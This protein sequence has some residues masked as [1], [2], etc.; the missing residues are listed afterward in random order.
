MILAM[1]RHIDEQPQD[2]LAMIRETLQR[3]DATLAD[4]SRDKVGDDA[5][6]GQVVRFDVPPL[7]GRIEWW[8]RAANEQEERF[9]MERAARLRNVQLARASAAAI[10]EQRIAKIEAQLL[11]VI[12]AMSRVTENVEAELRESRQESAEADARQANLETKL[13]ETLLQINQLCE[14]VAADCKSI[15]DLP[16]LLPSRCERPADHEGN[17]PKTGP[18]AGG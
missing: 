16:P 4:R 10:Y 3:V 18:A 15:L 8:K 2:V 1:S 9:A 11:S 14:T 13:A 12:R 5:Q 6:V 7:E 17:E